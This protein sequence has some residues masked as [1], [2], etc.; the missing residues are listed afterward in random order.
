M[1]IEGKAE[2]LAMVPASAATTIAEVNTARELILRLLRA[3]AAIA[4]AARARGL[5]WE[6][7]SERSVRLLVPAG[8]RDA[9]GRP[10]IV[11]A[12]EHEQTVRDV[13]NA[14]RDPAGVAV[15]VRLLDDG[16][17]EQPSNPA[18]SKSLPSPSESVEEHR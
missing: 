9:D 11:A 17:T 5:S 12:A 4:D 10:V 16:A 7:V 3:D 6:A 15:T 13:L 14:C 8:E 18:L 2:P 1:K